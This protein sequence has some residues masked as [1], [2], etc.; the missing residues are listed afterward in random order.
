M[1]E[2]ELSEIK[3]RFRHDKNNISKI[4][5]CYVNEKKEVVSQ[6]SQ[7]LGLM[8]EDDQ[9]SLLKVFKKTLSGTIGKNLIDIEFSTQQVCDSP[10]HKMLMDLR[11]SELDNEELVT[12]FYEKVINSVKIE[13]TYLILLAFE[14]YDVPVFRNDGLELED[15]SNDMFAYFLCSICPVKQTKTALGYYSYENMFKNIKQDYV[16]S[17]PEVGFMFPAFEDRCANIYNA[18]Y[19]T[20]NTS[21]SQDD[22]VD[23][24]FKVA[25]PMPAEV[26]K[27][28]FQ[29]VIA[30]SVENDCDYDFMQSVHTIFTEMVDEHKERK[31][32]EPLVLDKQTIKKVFKS[33]GASDEHIETFEEKFN[34]TFGAESTISPTNIVDTKHFE[35]KTADVTINVNPD[36]S[37]LIET[38]IIDGINYIMIRAEGGVEVNGVNIHFKKQEEEE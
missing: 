17:A 15:D 9:D 28:N 33:C 4:R 31:E 25:P 24:V 19:Y 6:F 13:G 18:V 34:D 38:R 30:E 37:H 36:R 2:K 11:D 8:S 20:K 10:E 7:S 1:N 26:Q 16:V 3:R 35:V 22:F 14:K 27:E 29:E 5:G 32:Q 12:S 23:A 21:L